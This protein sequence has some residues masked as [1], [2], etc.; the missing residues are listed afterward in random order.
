MLNATASTPTQT[1]QGREERIQA[2]L[3]QLRPAA[4]PTLRRMAEE[5]V[6]LPDEH[7]FG[8]IELTLRDLGHDLA[9]TAHQ[10]GLRAGKKRAT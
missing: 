4:E 1:P 5:L 6:D 10:A 9:A 8:P 2:L 7:A 3:A